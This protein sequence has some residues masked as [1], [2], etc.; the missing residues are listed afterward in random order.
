MIFLLQR[1]AMQRI[2]MHG[3]ASRAPTGARPHAYFYF[4]RFT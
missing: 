3:I 1:E 4:W 2:G